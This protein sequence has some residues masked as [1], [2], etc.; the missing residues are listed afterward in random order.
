MFGSMDIVCM[1]VLSGA[2]DEDGSSAT[3]EVMD[4]SYICNA[5]EHRMWEFWLGIY[6]SHTHIIQPIQPGL[7]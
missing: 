5:D 7:P 4:I 6:G 2:A 3:C 1:V